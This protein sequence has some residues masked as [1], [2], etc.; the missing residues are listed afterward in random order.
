MKIVMEPS[1]TLSEI[2]SAAKT[3]IILRNLHY[4][5]LKFSASSTQQLGCLASNISHLK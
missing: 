4:Y 2:V 1:G 3:V 5:R